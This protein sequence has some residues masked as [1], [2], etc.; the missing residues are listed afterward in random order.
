MTNYMRMTGK[1]I[2][3]P[4]SVRGILFDRVCTAFM[5]TGNDN[6]HTCVQIIVQGDSDVNIKL[7]VP[8]FESTETK[9]DL[10]TIN[11]GGGTYKFTL[12]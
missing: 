3:C 11:A 8:N 1:C 10:V 5:F 12:C 2:S 6:Q 4:D 7:H 9:D